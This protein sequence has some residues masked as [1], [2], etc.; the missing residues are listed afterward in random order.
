MFN[1]TIIDRFLACNTDKEDC[2][3]MLRKADNVFLRNCGFTE[4]I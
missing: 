2:Y 3:T 4:P 1:Q